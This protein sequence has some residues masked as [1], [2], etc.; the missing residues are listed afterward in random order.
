[1]KKSPIWILVL[2]FIIV[3]G[4]CMAATQS[5]ENA[6]TIAS[7]SV[8]ISTVAVNENPSVGSQVAIEKVPIAINRRAANLLEE[9]RD[10][11]PSWKNARL[12]SSVNL[13]FRPDIQNPSYYEF[14]VEP[15]GFIILSANQ[16]DWPITHFSST[17]KPIGNILVEKAKSSGKNAA[18]FYKLDSLS[19][20][21]EDAKEELASN[22][23]DMPMKV[24]GMDSALMKTAQGSVNLKPLEGEKEDGKLPIANRSVEKTGTESLPIQFQKWESWSALKEGYANNYKV[25]LEAQRNEAAEE[26]TIQQFLT[27]NGEGL[28]PGDEYVLALLF[29]DATFDISGTGKDYIKVNMM[30]R[31]GLSDALQIQVLNK[32]P[33]QG[34]VEFEVSISYKNGQ[35]EKV[36]FAVLDPTKVKRQSGDETNLKELGTILSTPEEQKLRVQI[37]WEPWSDPATAG[38]EADQRYYCQWFEDGCYIG[39][40]PVAWAMD[41]CW[42][43]HQSW[44]HWGDPWDHGGAYPG[45]APRHQDA[46][47]EDMIREIHDDVDTYCVGDSGA[48]NP[49][50]MDEAY[51]YL[52]GRT[53]MGFHAEYGPLGSRD[54]RNCARDAIRELH[55]PAVIGTGFY[56]HYP[57]AWQYRWREDR[58]G[59][60]TDRDVYVN[61]G[62]CG[63]GDGW[64]HLST[65]FCG[66]VYT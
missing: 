11:E 47:V 44:T 27:N 55:T 50:D 12:G 46:V 31:T 64:I 53:G 18:K 36:K 8:G 17:G 29:P 39:C 66:Y 40:G 30:K 52:E 22:L 41:F 6:K 62:W 65:F 15:S 33:P 60:F 26:W 58:W 54:C 21:A 61:Q 37:H 56:E 38:S 57:L 43:D 48:T 24:S 49:W 51:H 5:G 7:K 35:K 16:N 1:M 2:S 19:Y 14:V 9:L 20:V 4:L 59:W 34:K 45:D 32:M 23:G 13:F 63:D 3:S 28:F 42:A 25:F 10:Q